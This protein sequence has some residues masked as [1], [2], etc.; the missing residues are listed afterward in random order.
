MN[1]KHAQELLDGCFSREDRLGIAIHNAIASDD[2]TAFLLRKEELEELLEHWYNLFSPSH[3]Q[4][5]HNESDRIIL[6]FLH[7]YIWRNQLAMYVPQF[8]QVGTTA[9]GL[10][11][12]ELQRY[13]RFHLHQ[14]GVTHQQLRKASVKLFLKYFASGA[15]FV[16]VHSSE[17]L[18]GDGAES[19]YH[20][21]TPGV[22]SVRAGINDRTRIAPMHSH[23]GAVGNLLGGVTGSWYK[24]R[25]VYYPKIPIGET[26][27]QQ[28][29]PTIV[30]LLFGP[31]A[32][33]EIDFDFV[34]G[35]YG[36]TP[37]AMPYPVISSKR[38]NTFFQLEGWPATNSLGAGTMEVITNRLSSI[39]T[40]GSAPTELGRHNIDYKVHA[41]T[42]WNLSTFGAS[43]Y[44]EKR[45][46]TIFLAP[47]SWNPVPSQATKM[48]RYM[49]LDTKWM[50]SDLIRVAANPH[51]CVDAPSFS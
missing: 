29:C 12:Y 39:M 42:V 32:H 21:V 16:A 37:W 44:T 49:G 4:V 17:D 14:P 13:F 23:Y 45:A 24:D 33:G 9:S 25:G 41:R 2:T 51:P 5:Q 10:P 1:L 46:T 40:R 6:Q 28:R 3:N 34:R 50:A 47:R 27:P 26:A 35:M 36:G 22:T 38:T 19:L 15:H 18:V 8:V 31:T 20:L 43:A 7:G 30:S 11:I 48:M